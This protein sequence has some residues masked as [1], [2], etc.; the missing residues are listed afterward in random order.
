MKRNDQRLWASHAR[1]G[2]VRLTF[3]FAAVEVLW[4]SF[5][6]WRVYILYIF[7]SFLLLWLLTGGDIKK[8]AKDSVDIWHLT[9]SCVGMTPLN[10]A[11]QGKRPFVNRRLSFPSHC[12]DSHS[13]HFFHLKVDI[14]LEIN[15]G[16]CCDVDW[17][18]QNGWLIKWPTSALVP[19]A[20]TTA[21]VT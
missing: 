5:Y 15:R 7:F 19:V 1:S 16:V 2:N 20:T 13:F 17:M 9:R 21:F 11:S 10:A 6:Y 12:L 4:N 14:F 3:Y 8:K 18:D